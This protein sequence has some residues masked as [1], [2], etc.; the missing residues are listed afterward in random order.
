MI[1]IIIMN[2]FHYLI[3]NIFLCEFEIKSFFKTIFYNNLTEINKNVQYY[4][5]GI[6]SY[7]LRSARI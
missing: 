3:I 4:V 1:K 2:L 7:Q 5:D 6:E